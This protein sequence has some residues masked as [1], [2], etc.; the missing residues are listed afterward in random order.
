MANVGLSRPYIA[1]YH[2]DNGAVSYSK[3]RRL[4]KAVTTSYTPDTSDNNELYGDNGPAESDKQF[5]GGTLN[6][7]ITEL[8]VEDA[9][10][11]YGLE[12]TDVT[13]PGDEAPSGKEISF[14]G[15][16][17]IPYLGYGVI[18]KKIIDGKT[19]F[20]AV[21]FTKTQFNYPGDDYETQGKTINWKT[22]SLTATVMRDDTPTADWRKWAIFD[23]EE[24]AAK[25]LEQRL[26]ITP[27]TNPTPQA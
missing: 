14:G 16:S 9:A 24:Q 13:L 18:D 11:M 15:D 20:M 25:Y 27:Q 10:L 17:D 21:L 23:T 1:L 4:A 7:G 2:N 19:K 26:N 5:S 12:V 3:G 6:T 22:P 8:S